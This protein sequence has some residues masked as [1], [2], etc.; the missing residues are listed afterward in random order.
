MAHVLVQDGRSGH[1]NSENRLARNARGPRPFAAPWALMVTGLVAMLANS[2]A[3][4]AQQQG[5]LVTPYAGASVPA[6][7][8]KPGAEPE[9]LGAPRQAGE[10]PME[11]PPP[12][13]ID[14][15]SQ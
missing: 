8:P 15:F 10:G 7:P 12:R 4:C 14:S 9:R 2:S 6:Q 5:G 1:R 11:A 3:A 13:A